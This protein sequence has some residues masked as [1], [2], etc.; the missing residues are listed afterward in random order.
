MTVKIRNSEKSNTAISYLALRK[1]VGILGIS[2]PVA[3]IAGS[4]LSG[5]CKPFQP[6]ISCYY[7]SS[8]RSIFEG[9]LW[10]FAIILVFYRYEKAD[11]IISAIAGICAL[12]IAICPCFTSHCHHCDTSPSENE[13]VGYLH[14]AFASVFF[15]MLA[16]MTLCLFTKTNPV[17]TP[18]PQKLKRNI[19]YRVCGFSL[20]V[21]IALIVIYFQWLRGKS[22]AIDGM[23]PV[24][25]FETFALWSFGFAWIVKGEMVLGDEEK[26]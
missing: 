7:Y 22:T 11:N 12:G 18:T 26:V 1:A 6:T 20:L 3:L 24:F 17:K 23:N 21:W 16:V 19:I 14:I 5:Y 13:T 9:V 4:L 2:F 25:W 15:L 10:I 8:M